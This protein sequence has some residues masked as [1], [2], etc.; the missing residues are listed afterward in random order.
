MSATRP[1]RLWAR[2]A[3]VAAELLAG[4]LA[5]VPIALA[6]AVSGPSFTNAVL[7]I[8][9]RGAP[10][11]IRVRE[12]G[13]D[14]RMR[15]SAPSTWGIAA[16]GL[17]I[18][19]FDPTGARVRVTR[20]YAQGARLQLD[21]PAIILRKVRVVG[22]AIEARRQR[23]PGP[24]DAHPSPILIGADQVELFDVHYSAVEDYPLKEASAHEIRGGLVDVR[25][26]LGARELYGDGWLAGERFR[27]GGLQVTEIELPF[28]ELDASTLRFDGRIDFANAPGRV[29]GEVATFHRRSAVK[30]DARLQGADVARVV[31]TA[32]GQA[33]SPLL[34][35]LDAQLEVTGGGSLPRGGGYSIG[36]VAMRD[37]RI[38]VEDM[39]PFIKD[40]IRVAPYLAM[41]EDD[42]VLLGDMR[43]EMKLSRGAVELRELVFH[44]PKRVIEIRGYVNDTDKHVVIRFVPRRDPERRAG[45]GVVL[46]GKDRF[47]F[48]LAKKED[49]LPFGVER[50][51]GPSRKERRAERKERRRDR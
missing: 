12:L 21:P 48:R 44:A 47:R 1:R 43:G 23:P 31:Q 19:P 51:D 3:C 25:Y 17:T 11:T 7:G 28:V 14:P 50:D 2:V 35:R 33:R 13:L 41:S 16:E 30:L 20:V 32:T 9:T 26:D 45:V 8:A 24:W 36:R 38:P 18:V 4:L 29:T 5:L 40:L 37:G 22:L 49:L 39:K 42:H 46:Y 34:G 15:W 6:G 27:T 10:I